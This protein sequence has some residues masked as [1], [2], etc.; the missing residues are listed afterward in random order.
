MK[1]PF[2]TVSHCLVVNEFAS[3]GLLNAPLHP[4]DE[5]SLIFKHPSHGVFDQLLGIFA[6][7]DGQLLEPR[8]NVGREMDFHGLRVRQILPSG[9]VGLKVKLEGVRTAPTKDQ[10][11]P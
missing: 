2:D 1:Q 6:V 5:T 11:D 3:V 7:G 8:F 4:C 9:K 10:V